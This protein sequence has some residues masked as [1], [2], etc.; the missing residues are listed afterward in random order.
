[1]YFKADLFVKQVVVGCILQATTGAPRWYRQ[2]T[3]FTYCGKNARKPQNPTCFP[4]QG[5]NGIYNHV[6]TVKRA[7]APVPPKSRGVGGMET[8]LDQLTCPKDPETTGDRL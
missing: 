4:L 5:F 7:Y 1:M 3:C 2:P 8:I 6:A